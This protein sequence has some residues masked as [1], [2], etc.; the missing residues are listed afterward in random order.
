MPN[1]QGKGIG[2]I[3]NAKAH[4]KNPQSTIKSA[5]GILLPCE[6]YHHYLEKLSF[7]LPHNKLLIT[8]PAN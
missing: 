7:S 6:D 8:L 2:T 4:K 3:I 5:L 1:S